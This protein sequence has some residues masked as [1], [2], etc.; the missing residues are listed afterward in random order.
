MA[1]KCFGGYSGPFCK[2]CE[3][4]TYKYNFG[5]GVCQTCNNKP[6]NS[7]YD[8]IAQSSSQCSFQCVEG[9]E[10]VAVNPQCMSSIDLQV[11]RVG[12]ANGALVV[13]VLFCL[14][15]LV[16]WIIISL[17]SN[18][19][20]ARTKDLYSTVYDGVLFSDASASTF[21]DDTNTVIGPTSL[22]M[23]D[24]DIWSHTH[25]MYLIG[26]NSIHFPWFMP[27]DFQA[28]SLSE[29]SKEKLIK[30][31]K[32]DQWVLDWSQC[33]SVWYT[34]SR[35]FFPYFSE[36]VH[37]ASRRH[38]F[39]ALAEGLYNAFE[40]AEW[41]DIT[42]RTIRVSS[43]E[44]SR[45]AWVDFLDYRKTKSSFKRPQLPITLL[46]GGNGS[47]STPYKI[48]YLDD[49]LAKSLVYLDPTT[50]KSKLPYFF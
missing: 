35:V 39:R 14:F 45:L 21:A 40:V 20:K 50:L 22:H 43:D 48:N 38:H 1:E 4:G 7:F 44:E 28:N 27:K 10:P 13:A 9:F 5:F 23:R 8:A 32:H 47:L 17:R 34:L 19:I 11:E 16:L 2:P 37:R 42:G 6:E 41:E 15:S 26:E 24:S 3:I 12:G 25:R 18:C 31:I 49:P 33:Q 30:F 29:P 36:Q 46:S